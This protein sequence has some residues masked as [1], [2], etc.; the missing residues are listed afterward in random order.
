VDRTVDSAP[1]EEARVRSVD[2]RIDLLLGDVPANRLYHGTNASLT[3][4]RK[5][6]NRGSIRTIARRSARRA[7]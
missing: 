4:W 6:A 7:A 5:S 3:L 1:T 2:D